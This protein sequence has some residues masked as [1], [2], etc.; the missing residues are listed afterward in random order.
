MSLKINY[1]PKSKILLL[2]LEIT[3]KFLSDGN[4]FVD[5]KSLHIPPRSSLGAGGKEIHD[6]MVSIIDD[7]KKKCSGFSGNL[8][9]QS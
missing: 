1:M 3:G 4:F 9:I 6:I 5:F 7:A 8:P 2:Q